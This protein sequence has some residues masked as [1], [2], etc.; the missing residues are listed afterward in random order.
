MLVVELRNQPGELAHV[1]ELLGGEHINIEYAYCSSGGRNGKTVGV[2]KV[3]NT[4]KA[5]RV[6]GYAEG[7]VVGQSS[8]LFFTPEDRAQGV[9]EQELQTALREGRA[10]DEAE[11]GKLAAERYRRRVVDRARRD[12]EVVH[13][14]TLPKDPRYR[15]GPLSR[16]R[17]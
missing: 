10:G 4:E 2:F 7:E 17:S 13:C 16:R 1:C 8:F 11:E 6:L 15:T 14:L 9:P 5:M 12:Q 3:S